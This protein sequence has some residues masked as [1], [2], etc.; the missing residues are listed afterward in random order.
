MRFLNLCAG[1]LCFACLGLTMSARGAAAPIVF[2]SQA[3]LASRQQ[4][5]RI[6]PKGRIHGG[7][8]RRQ[9]G[10]DEL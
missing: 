8:R 9:S 5:M 3:K 2:T 10:T 4:T 1:L 6:E 7:D